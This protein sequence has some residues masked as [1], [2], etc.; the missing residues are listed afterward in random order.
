M[1]K[2][3]LDA[4]TSAPG[5]SQVGCPLDNMIDLGESVQLSQHFQ[6][7]LNWAWLYSLESIIAGAAAPGGRGAGDG[8]PFRRL[9]SNLFLAK[10]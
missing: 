3:D 8:S 6:L 4:R 2:P 9:L 7:S 5:G 1:M 10:P